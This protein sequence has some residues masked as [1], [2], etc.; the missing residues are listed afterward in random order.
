MLHCNRAGRSDTAISDCSQLVT[1]ARRL[2]ELAL[3]FPSSP[4]IPVISVQITAASS[5]VCSAD[6][7]ESL[8]SL[9]GAFEDAVANI[10]EALEAIQEQLTTL[11]GSTDSNSL[12]TESVSSTT[13]SKSP[14]TESNSLPTDIISS[15]AD[16]GS[17]GNCVFPFVF[18]NRLSDRCTTMYGGEPWCATSVDSQGSMTEFEYCTDPSCPGLAGNSEE[19]SVHPMNAVGKCCKFFYGSTVQIFI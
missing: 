13:E 12:T 8:T 5:V 9:E 10:V 17:C 7:L 16:S 14:T 15:T 2:T 6:E 11:T 18:N 19:M 1:V 3:N 4:N